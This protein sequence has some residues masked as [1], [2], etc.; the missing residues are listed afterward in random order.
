M[1]ILQIIVTVI[2]L[3]VACEEL[4]NYL[5]KKTNHYRNS[6]KLI[7]KFTQGVPNG[8]DIA[9]IGPGQGAYGISY[10]D[11]PKRGFNFSTAPQSYEYGFK[12]LKQ[13]ADKIN[14]KCIIIII[15]C[16][17]SF[18]NNNEYIKRGYADNYYHFLDKQYIQSY[19]R[20][21]KFLV[22]R[23]LLIRPWRALYILKDRPSY[24]GIQG[25]NLTPEQREI[26][27]DNM[28]KGWLS[29]F[30]LHDLLDITQA[31]SHHE[32]FI[33]KIG[34]LAQIIE[35]CHT[36]KL[37][38]VFVLPPASKR[39]RSI[40]GN[41]FMEAFVYNNLDALSYEDIPTL[42]YYADQRFEKD[43][44]YQDSIFLNEKGRNVFSEVLFKEIAL[45][46][47]R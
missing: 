39:L 38:P 8:I 46:L 21:R 16:P 28:R 42:D 4:L 37:R 19:S 5:Y 31:D 33:K 15:M 35:Y 13:Y 26:S 24:N 14:E 7:N 44:L 17:L 27:V 25:D 11:C 29:E 20:F 12:I 23:P 34:I 47:E 41:E 40:I 22:S 3:I 10:D 43:D 30:S 36:R 2:F 18:G 32:A 9:N 6:M 1:K 45:Q